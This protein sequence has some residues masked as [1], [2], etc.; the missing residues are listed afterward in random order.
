M[1]NNRLDGTLGER[2][3]EKNDGSKITGRS[4]LKA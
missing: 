2:G 3:L 4:V 1:T